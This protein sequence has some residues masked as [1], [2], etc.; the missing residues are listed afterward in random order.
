ML[1]ALIASIDLRKDLDAANEVTRGAGMPSAKMAGR[2]ANSPGRPAMVCGQSVP[3]DEGRS[4]PTRQGSPC[5]QGRGTRPAHALSPRLMIGKEH[6]LV[7]PT[8]PTTRILTP[9]KVT[10]R[11]QLVVPLRSS[12][13]DPLHPGACSRVGLT[14]IES[15]ALH[16]VGA[17]GWSGAR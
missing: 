6:Q 16:C 13:D 2:L 1:C 14:S 12:D 8:H 7:T 4:P 5:T 3:R 15:T 17:V 9:R 10:I 11:C